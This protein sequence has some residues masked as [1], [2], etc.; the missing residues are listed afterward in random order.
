MPDITMCAGDNCPKKDTC[1]R[2][3]AVPNPY[4]QAYFMYAPFD[5]DQVNCEYFSAIRENDS[6]RSE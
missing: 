2:S 4:R 5:H 1:Y 3:M 6:V